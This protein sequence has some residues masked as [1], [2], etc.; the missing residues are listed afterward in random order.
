MPK[1]RPRKKGAQIFRATGRGVPKEVASL[2]EHM[3]C[4]GTM[5]GEGVLLDLLPKSGR[6]DHVVGFVDALLDLTKALE[7]FPPRSTKLRLLQAKCHYHVD[8]TG[9][10][11]YLGIPARWVEEIEPEE[12]K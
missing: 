12:G 1:G 3:G 5:V 6:Y 9:R 7:R 10:K 2:V 11:A 8:A 4:T